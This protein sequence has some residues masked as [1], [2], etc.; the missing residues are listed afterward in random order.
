[1]KKQKNVVQKSIWHGTQICNNNKMEFQRFVSILFLLSFQQKPLLSNS[2][3]SK[4][5]S[6]HFPQVDLSPTDL[7][8]ASKHPVI[9]GT[10]D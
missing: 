3:I 5:H 9:I 1:M 10:S 7:M 6:K 2:P 4:L 8:H